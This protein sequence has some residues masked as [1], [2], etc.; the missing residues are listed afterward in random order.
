MKFKTYC[1]ILLSVF[2]LG[3]TYLA[4]TINTFHFLYGAEIY[5]RGSLIVPQKTQIGLFF[6]FAMFLLL[7]PALGIPYRWL[8]TL[9]LL[10]LVPLYG[11]TLTLFT[12]RNIEKIGWNAS[13]ILSITLGAFLVTITFYSGNKIKKKIPQRSLSETMLLRRLK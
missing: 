12:I 10:F 11:A 3:A 4:A 1:G 2:C 7:K 13:S 9:G 8:L 5:R 6:A